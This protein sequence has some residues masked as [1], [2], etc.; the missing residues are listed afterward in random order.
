[1]HYQVEGRRGGNCQQLGVPVQSQWQA[2]PLAKPCFATSPAVTAELAFAEYAGYPEVT[3][4]PTPLNPINPLI[5]AIAPATPDY[6]PSD[7]AANKVIPIG[8]AMRPA[9]LLAASTPSIN[10]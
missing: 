8:T 3:P 2:C 7:Y 5:V 10:Q 1:L 4:L 9:L 6:A